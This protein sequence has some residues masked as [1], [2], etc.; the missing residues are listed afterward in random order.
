MTRLLTTLYPGPVRV[1]EHEVPEDNIIAR[2]RAEDKDSGAFGQ[3]MM[4][5]TMMMMMIMM[6]MI[7]WC[8]AWQLARTR[9]STPTS[10]WPRARTGRGSSSWSP[11][12][13]LSPPPSTR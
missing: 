8:T 9:V 11:S 5:M 10:R 4:T 1:T 7:R 6:M 3:V 2:F 12:W 13:T